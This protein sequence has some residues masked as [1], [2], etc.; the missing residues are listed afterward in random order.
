MVMAVAPAR[1]TREWQQAQSIMI[2]RLSH[3]RQL[4]SAKS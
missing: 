1:S 4:G 3:L 2:P